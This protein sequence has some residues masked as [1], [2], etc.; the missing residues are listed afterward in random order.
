MSRKPFAAIVVLVML[1][2][3]A[4]VGLTVRAQ[5]Q[6]PSNEAKE[7]AVKVT[8][9]GAAMFDARDAKGLAMTYTEDARLEIYSRDKDTGELK[10]ESR[11][12][13]GEIQSY[14]ED[15]FKSSDAIHARNTVETARRLDPATLTISGT[16]EPNTESAE[17]MRLPFNQIRTR[18][19]DA[20]KIV[21]LQLFI[22]SQK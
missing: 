12:G 3:A 4:A 16:F 15:H 1:S 2:I 9:A 14:Y 11:V 13:R 8:T 21:N 6:A 22:M 17:P 5:A 18:K 19:G 10:V 20:W 7:I